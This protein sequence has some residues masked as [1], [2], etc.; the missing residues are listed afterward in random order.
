VTRGHPVAEVERAQQRAQQRDLESGQ[1]LCAHLQLLASLLGEQE[2]AD[3]ILEREQDGGEEDDGWK[4]QVGVG[5]RY[6]QR[7]QASRQLRRQDRDYRAPQM[8]EQ[9]GLIEVDAVDSDRSQIDRERSDEQGEHHQVEG[10]LVGRQVELINCEMEARPGG[11][12][13]RRIND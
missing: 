8:R 13:K 7:E 10:D 2:L 9:A 6:R 12:R 5:E 3:E 1:L 11:E 4:P